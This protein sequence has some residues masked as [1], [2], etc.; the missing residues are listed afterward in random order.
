M[1]AT[2]SQPLEKKQTNPR[3]M[4]QPTIK[5]VFD[6]TGSKEATRFAPTLSQDQVTA[7]RLHAQQKNW[8]ALRHFP[9]PLDEKAALEWRLFVTQY[10]LRHT[11]E[12]LYKKY[13]LDTNQC[14]VLDNMHQAPKDTIRV[15]VGRFPLLDLYQLVSTCTIRDLRQGD[16]SKMTHFIVC[17]GHGEDLNVALPPPLKLKVYHW[18]E[19]SIQS[20]Q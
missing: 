16:P 12:V 1:S 7:L 18:P 3:L 20:I 13:N 11:R 15:A 19:R 17:A 14:T 5:D 6:N 10:E 9:V 2:F 4:T 8:R